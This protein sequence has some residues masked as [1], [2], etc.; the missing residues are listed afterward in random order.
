M[1]RRALSALNDAYQ[2][3]LKI[4]AIEEKH[5]PMDVLPVEWRSRLGGI[6]ARRMTIFR[7]G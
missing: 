1:E 4:R 2:R 5:Y 7:L 6:P 3:A